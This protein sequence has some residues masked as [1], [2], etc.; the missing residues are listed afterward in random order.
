VKERERER[1]IM[2]KRWVDTSV[3]DTDG[4]GMTPMNCPWPAATSISL[5]NFVSPRPFHVFASRDENSRFLSIE[6]IDAIVRIEGRGQTR[7]AGMTP[8][9]RPGVE[10]CANIQST[11]T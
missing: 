11:L 6:K 10:Q 7:T 5:R 9:N 3:T 4:A 8:M 2:R 1:E